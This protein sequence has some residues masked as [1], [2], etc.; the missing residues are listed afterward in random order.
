MLFI[1]VYVY[2][3]L[4]FYNFSFSFLY[5]MWNRAKVKGAAGIRTNIHFT[6]LNHS[7]G[8]PYFVV[9]VLMANKFL[10]NRN[11]IFSIYFAEAF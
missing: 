6:R 8:I 4:F 2:V 11:A 3:F 5:V 9:K 10:E 7:H 1:L